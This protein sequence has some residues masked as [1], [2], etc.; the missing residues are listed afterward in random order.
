MIV[1]AICLIGFFVVGIVI[2]R[3]EHPKSDRPTEPST[4]AFTRVVEV[5]PPE[6]L[7]ALHLWEQALI[8]AREGRWDQADNLAA[9]AR[10]LTQLRE[11]E[12]AK[13]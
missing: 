5:E 8:R 7:Q 3:N 1:G 6:L 10:R 12:K 9:E 11:I 2:A 4:S 13:R